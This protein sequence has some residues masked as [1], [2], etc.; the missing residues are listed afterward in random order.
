LLIMDGRSVIIRIFED[1]RRTKKLKTEMK[2]KK[3]RGSGRPFGSG[4]DRLYRRCI[5]LN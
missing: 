3:F 4:T 2:S 1:E 5:Y